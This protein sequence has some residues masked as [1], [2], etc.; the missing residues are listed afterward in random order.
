[1][2][3]GDAGQRRLIVLGS[4]GSIGTSTLDVVAHL[5]RTGA[6]SLEIVGLAAGRDAQT[7]GEQAAR[8]GVDHV[9]LADEQS[10]GALSGIAHVDAGPDAPERLVRAVAR[11]GDLVLG[12]IVGSAGVPATVAAIE[13]GCDVALANKETLV[14]A[15]AIVMPLVRDR[16]VR[17]EPVDSEHSAIAQCLRSGR[18]MDEV[19]RIVLTASG[20]PFRGWSAERLAAATPEQAL[21]HPTWSMGRKITIDSATLMNKALEVSCIASSSSSTAP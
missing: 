13:C 3:D 2:T 10:A 17:L 20:G 11:P 19:R 5:A 18:S 4:T 6:A 7:L 12:A 16:G 1:M 21:V 8:F 15:G 14:A 9:A